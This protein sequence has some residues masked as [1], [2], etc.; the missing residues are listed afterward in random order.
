VNVKVTQ[1]S[2]REKFGGS[3]P[4]Q[5]DKVAH[6]LIPSIKGK[7]LTKLTLRH[8]RLNICLLIYIHASR[9]IN[10]YHR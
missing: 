9:K 6:A 10:N 7:P 1:S 4:D 8:E 3:P 2:S 5:N